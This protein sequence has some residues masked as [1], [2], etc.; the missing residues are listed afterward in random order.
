VKRYRFRLD[1][2][3]RVR[4]IQEEQARMGVA[5]AR[6]VV[7][8]AEIAAV[9]RREQYEEAGMQPVR[10]DIDDLIVARSHHERLGHA[11]VQ[12]DAAV[13]AAGTAL[14]HQR[15]VWDRSRVRVKALEQLDDRWRAEHRIDADREMERQVDDLVQGVRHRRLQDQ[16]LQDQSSSG[17]RS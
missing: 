11:V 15:A 8:E 10:G 2:V 6:A 9:E 14:D 3:L 13:V 7:A 4:R 5:R 17:D 1:T 12:A 16:K